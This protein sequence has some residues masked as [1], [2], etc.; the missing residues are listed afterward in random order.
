MDKLKKTNKL[1]RIQRN[2]CSNMKSA[3][4]DHLSDTKNGTSINCWGVNHQRNC[5]K[6]I[7]LLALMNNDRRNAL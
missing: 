4:R 3:I 6:N 2:K 1:T 5:C 7:D